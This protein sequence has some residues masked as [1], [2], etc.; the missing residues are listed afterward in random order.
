MTGPLPRNTVLVG[1]AL[2][3]LRELPDASVDCVMTSPPYFLLRNY[4]VIGQIGLEDQVDHWVAKLRIVAR[5]VSRVLKPTGAFWLN[6]G[7]SYSRDQRFGAAPK[8]LL[9]APER[10][11]LALV[12]DGWIIR[13]KVIWQKSNPMPASVRDRLTCSWEVIY[14]LVR[15]NDYH[16]DLDAIRVPHRSARRTGQAS[17]PSMAVYPPP[18]AMPERWAGPL[19]ASNSGLAKLK[20]RGVVG[21]PFGANPRDVWTMA[22]ANFRGA[23]FATF[24]PALVERP[25][26]ATCPERTCLRCGNPWRRDLIRQVGHLAVR[27]EL[28]PGC[29]CRQA[30][31]PGLI[32]DPFFGA[33]TVGVV[34][35]AYGRDWLGVELNP[36]FAALAVRRI[37]AERQKRAQ[38]E[39]E[40]A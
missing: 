6:L 34:A 9:F 14:F 21:H 7:D 20:A 38:A 22:T 5:E 11:A 12:S 16:F 2:D 23:H 18:T 26:L 39:A 40:A 10:L 17:K 27:G 1:D 19:S 25:L 8:S 24:P 4:Q 30:W 33:G 13:N 35:E 3:R 15:S 31:R 32:L 28:H 37:E 29:R 36:D